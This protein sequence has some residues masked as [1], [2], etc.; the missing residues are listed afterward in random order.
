MKNYENDICKYYNSSYEKRDDERDHLCYS[1]F[2]VLGKQNKQYIWNTTFN[3]ISGIGILALLTNITSCHGFVKDKKS[4]FI[5]SCHRKSVSYY[6]SKLFVTL[7]I[8]QVP[9]EMCLY[10]WNTSL[11]QKYYVKKYFAMTQYRAIPYAGN[12]LKSITSFLIL[13][14]IC[15]KVLHL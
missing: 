10:V 8:F 13:L 15:I 12:T 1:P 6:L 2:H 14:I 9:K 5:L 11:L 4:I 3:D 7:K